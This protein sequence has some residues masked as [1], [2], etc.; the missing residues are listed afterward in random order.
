M[1]SLLSRAVGGI[2]RDDG[3]AP[4]NP[5]RQSGG[6]GGRNSPY[7]RPADS[8]KHDKFDQDSQPYAEPSS[9]KGSLAARLASTGAAAPAQTARS[10]KLV[11]RNLH[12]EVSERE[13]ELL[14]VQIGPIASGP[15]IKTTPLTLESLPPSVDAPLPPRLKF[16]RSGRSEGVAWVTYS[17]E[18]HAAQAKEA[19]DGASAK[20]QNIKVDF[21]FR[22]DR[23]F[24]RG[25]P[26]PG[27]LLARLES[28]S[29]S[30]GPKYASRGGPRGGDG[31]QRG[32]GASFDPRDSRSA[33]RG[34]ARGGRG[35]RGGG[36]EGGREPRER[37]EPKTNEDLDRELEAYLKGPSGTEEKT[38]TP[39]PPPQE[40][41]SGGDV[42]MA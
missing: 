31:P 5:R 24:E 28:E 10:S 15:K 13:L 1:S 39:A 12:Y 19:F 11:I 34:G 25:V 3:S 18:E 27:S 14:F 30:R 16:D 9:P 6:T 41:V 33:P 8:W 21:D 42:E 20:G 32:V 17:S 22:P 7:A 29:S 26:A 37:K 2:R 38:E 40:A 36:R 35:G 23:A 4:A